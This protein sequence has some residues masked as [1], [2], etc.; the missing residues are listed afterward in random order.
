FERLAEK[1]PGPMHEGV[2]NLHYFGAHGV[3]F[4]RTRDQKIARADCTVLGVRLDANAS[5]LRD[6]HASVARLTKR[7]S[8]LSRDSAGDSRV[9]GA[10][11]AG[12]AIVA[13]GVND[14][15]SAS[16]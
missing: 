2:A 3:A 13:L 5:A 15:Y 11:G 9:V 14:D 7:Q 4:R 6:E 16:L 10:N 8:G 12:H 1:R